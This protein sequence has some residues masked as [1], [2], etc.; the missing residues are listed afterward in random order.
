[1]DLNLPTG[2]ASHMQQV[3]H[4]LSQSLRLIDDGFKQIVIGMAHRILVNACVQTARSPRDRGQRGAEVMRDGAQERASELFDFRF[5]FCSLGSFGQVVPFD[6]KRD[7][8]RIGFEKLP[9][10]DRKRRIRFGRLYG[11]HTS[12]ILRGSKGR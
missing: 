4:Q 6:C 11:H 5:N 8:C 1:M 9:S 7:L 12:D 10:F 3:L 2:K